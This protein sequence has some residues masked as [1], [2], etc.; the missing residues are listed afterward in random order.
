MLACL[1][2]SA[3]IMFGPKEIMVSAA[4][5]TVNLTVILNI[6]RHYVMRP[7]MIP[8]SSPLSSLKLLFLKLLSGFSLLATLLLVVV[9][10]PCSWIYFEK[11]S[12]MVFATITI[13]RG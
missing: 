11:C 10:S 8:I 3:L 4:A 6:P 2:P 7:I 13:G 1:T 9:Y 12:V 5:G